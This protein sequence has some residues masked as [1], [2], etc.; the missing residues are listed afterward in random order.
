MDSA[1]HAILKNDVMWFIK[2]T[3]IILKLIK[4]VKLLALHGWLNTRGLM[5][6]RWLANMTWG[7][8]TW[9]KKNANT[10]SFAEKHLM[11]AE[12]KKKKEEK[13]KHFLLQQPQNETFSLCDTLVLVLGAL[14]VPKTLHTLL[15]GDFA[16]GQHTLIFCSH[17]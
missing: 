17:T 3:E 12:N 7:N 4:F 5:T 2:Y 10:Q 13:K 6:P 16:L 14:S 15:H 11:I 8:E 1:F 9:K